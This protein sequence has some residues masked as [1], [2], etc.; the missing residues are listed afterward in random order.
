MEIRTRDIEIEAVDGSMPVFVAEPVAT[1]PHPAVIVIMEAFGRVQH[2]CDV[3]SRIASEGYVAIAPDFY[4]REGVAGRVPYDELPRA[5]ELLQQ[6]DDAK[7]LDDMRTTL[8]YLR[9]LGTVGNSKIGVTGFCMG[10]RL[11]FFAA[12]SLP[13]EFDA[14]AP[15]Y[16]AFTVGHLPQAD[17]IRCPL[18]LFFGEEDPYIPAGEVEAIGNKLDELGKQFQL[19]SYAG[20][21]HGFFCN[22]RESFNEA[23]ASNAWNELKEFFAG[24]LC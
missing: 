21:D 20:A 17:S 10:G 15:F 18:Y 14:A 23:A 5:L 22:E 4:Y 3:A 1:G 19:K 8:D 9:G 16:G 24:T 13:G 6:F 12:C 7:F 2:I 11:T